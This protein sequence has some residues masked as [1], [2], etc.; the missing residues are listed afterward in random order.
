ME[1]YTTGRELCCRRENL[2]WLYRRLQ[3][4]RFQGEQ[5]TQQTIDTYGRLRDASLGLLYRPLR[6]LPVVYR[7]LTPQRPIHT[8]GPIRPFGKLTFTLL[9]RDRVAGW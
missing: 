9:R 5:R 8:R 3:P 1:R 2:L 7:S 4:G 6:F